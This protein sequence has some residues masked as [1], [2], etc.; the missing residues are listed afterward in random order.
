MCIFEFLSRDCCSLRVVA[1]N[2][3]MFL[4]FSLSESPPFMT[5]NT[6][7]VNIH[8]FGIIS[9][10]E[11]Q[12]A[13]QTYESIW[14]EG[15][16]VLSRQRMWNRATR[17]FRRLVLIKI[18]QWRTRYTIL[19]QQHQSCV[20]V[21]RAL[22]Y[23]NRWFSHNVRHVQWWAVFLRFYAIWFLHWSSTHFKTSLGKDRFPLCIEYSWQRIEPYFKTILTSRIFANGTKLSEF[24]LPMKYLTYCIPQQQT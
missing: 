23:S 22:K 8:V 14:F 17:C 6:I 13:L 11:N 16:L 15:L 18:R 3:L 1:N 12:R 10:S 2:N 19:F 24:L 5:W 21:L 20:V 7:S 9:R 4:L